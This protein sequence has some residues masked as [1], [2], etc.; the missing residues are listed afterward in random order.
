MAKVTPSHLA[1]DVDHDSGKT[2]SVVPTNPAQARAGRRD[3]TERLNSVNPAAAAFSGSGSAAP[4]SGHHAGTDRTSTNAGGGGGGA[5]SQGMSTESY[6]RQNARFGQAL[7]R[8]VQN[9]LDGECEDEVDDDKKLRKAASRNK[10]LPEQVDALEVALAMAFREHRHKVEEIM[11]EHMESMEAVEANHKLEISKLRA[12]NAMLRERLGLAPEQPSPDLFQ[13][14]ALHNASQQQH[15]SHHGQGNKGGKQAGGTDRNRNKGSS[16]NDDDDGEGEIRL[17]RGNKENKNQ[18]MGSWQQFVA[19]VPNGSALQAPQPWQPLPSDTFAPVMD[20]RGNL[21][22][23]MTGAGPHA[24]GQHEDEATSELSDESKKK[25]AR[26]KVVD[27][28]VASQDE[29]EASRQSMNAKVLLKKEEKKNMGAALVQKMGPHPTTGAAHPTPEDAEEGFFGDQSSDWWIV[30]PHSNRRIAWDLTSLT[31]VVWDMISIP[32]SAF[33]L[34][35]SLFLDFMEWTTRIFWTCD[36]GM[37]TVTGV[38][39]KDGSVQLEFRYIIRRYLTTWFPL[40]A[41]IVA[42]DWMEFLAAGGSGSFGF[43]RSLRS[44]RVVRL[45]RLVRMKEVMAQITERVQSEKLSFVIKVF[46]MTIFIISIAHITACGWWGIGDREISGPTWVKHYS[47]E[48]ATLD[49]QYLVS[50]HWSLTQF[51]GGMDEVTPADPLER[52]YAVGMWLFAFMSAAVVV[53]VLT[54]NLTQLHIIGGSRSRQLATLRK[55]LKQNSIS[56]NLALRMQRSAQHALSADLTADVVELLPVVSEPLRV[57]MHFEMYTSILNVQ[58]FFAAYITECP[59]VMRRVC[60]YAMGFFLLANGDIVF[61]KGESPSHPKMYFVVKGQCE[62]S[63]TP[64]SVMVSEKQYLAEAVLWTRWT[65][66]GTLTSISDVKLAALDAKVFQ[67]ISDRFKD[68]A[69][70]DP[71]LY[72][73]DFVAHLNALDNVNDL[74][75]IKYK[76]SWE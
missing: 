20:A 21:K 74:S 29:L 54:S 76:G 33:S 49:S 24:V 55:Y 42:S 15:Q 47:Y 27:V 35:S 66:Q 59:Q 37:S 64:E 53:S 73:A 58:P 26:F 28:F 56:S 40:D 10:P 63:Q 70:F 61:S 75:G 72:A 17:K 36:M 52:L 67:D 51:T 16:N 11:E 9:M 4:P 41:F 38:T 39:L 6:S 62:Y 8:E 3:R 2:M 13:T 60:H 50:L 23:G 32:L 43:L 34:P 12:E 65:H 44:V 25:K 19:W 71:K 68:A 7:D 31:L 22:R 30:H 14:V 1:I 69:T 46:Q 48:N 18:P 57:E 5:G 45:M